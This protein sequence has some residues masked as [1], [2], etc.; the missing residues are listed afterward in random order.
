M[1]LAKVSLDD[2]YELGSGRVFLTGLQALVRLPMMQRQ[3]DLAQGLNTAGFVSGYRGSPLG[4]YDAALWGAKRYLK[5]H[6]IHFKAGLNEDLAATAVWGTQQVGLW[7][8]ADY[9]G[10]FS[11][12]YGKGPGVDRS[13]DAIKHGNFNG[14]SPYG[15]VLAVAGDDH[16][17]KSSTLPH[18]SEYAFQAAFIPVIH[19]AGVQEY[20][21]YGLYGFAMSRFAG[22]WVGFKAVGDTVESTAS[23]SIDPER[24]K[25]VLPEDFEMP[26]GGL[27]IRYPDMFMELETRM[28]TG[29]MP[30]VQAF[31]R[32]NGLDRIVMDAP[33][34]RFGIA[35]TGKSYLDVRQ[36]LDELG[37]DEA[38]AAELGIRLYKVALTWPLEPEGAR[39]FAR[40]L[41]EILVV[42]EK[43][44]LIEDQL[45]KLLF[46][47]ADAPKRIIGKRD[48]EGR[49]LLPEHGEISPG[50]IA[51]TLHGRLKRFKEIQE[52]EQRI[53]RLD[54][55][56]A[57]A[58]GKP[59]SVLRTP[60]FCSGCP[61]N[62]STAVPAGSRAM[63]GIGC[64]GM[65][66]WHP[67]RNTQTI[68]HM[69]AEGV[70]WIGQSPFTA[71]EHVFQ[72]LG[73]GTYF[74]S[75][76]LAI[77]ASVDA[78]VNIT[79]KILYND[80]V[81]MTGGQPVVDEASLSP[82]DIA[83]QV[84]AEGVKKV[85]LVSDEPDKYPPA[86]DFGP[87]TTFHHRDDLDKVQRDLRTIPGVTVLIYDQ[88]CAAEKRRRR[89]RGLY[90]DPPK[91][92]FIN[93]AVC[94]ACGD[95]SVQSNC[96]SVEPL[97][98]E[99]GRKRQINQSACNK[100]FSCIKGFCPSFVTVHGGALRKAKST[101]GADSD[102]AQFEQLPSADVPSAGEPYGILITGIGG[103]GVVTIGA[104]LGDGRPPR[105]QGLFDSG[106][107]RPGAEERRRHQ[108]CAYCRRSGRSARRA[109]RHRRC[110]TG[111]GLRYRRCRNAG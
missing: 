22:C 27:N 36:A 8:G 102:N 19:P 72:N 51:R 14:T 43:R 87:G 52:F 56:E 73:D 16:G 34:A 74:H 89:K 39:D 91:R 97:E 69:G 108:P 3:R 29:K 40:G 95:C 84:H 62:T 67:E 65:A 104:L 111:F 20:I 107:R 100:D 78:G 6:H 31:A 45:T 81:A 105:R 57:A 79:Y 86:M 58:L 68:T 37:I 10:V 47:D 12:W 4:G 70:N 18:Q 53:A 96:V 49:P 92:A 50:M 28:V 98:T 77:R 61:H 93:D 11:I 101:G 99:F 23:V 9:D 17:C 90:P 15:G 25:I 44:P 71:T 109:H 55:I 106:Y 2:K 88:T 76:I 63:A 83:R 64:H 32:A 48:E 66:L 30:A 38:M 82:A 85:V 21:D 75:G 94:E 5:E 13:G 26:P 103:T 33:K 7:P 35:T 41:E 80:A 110:Q 60:Y 1:K 42:E 24:I 54:G 59:P 46:H